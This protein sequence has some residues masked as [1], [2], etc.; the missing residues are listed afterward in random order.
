MAK[1]RKSKADE[2]SSASESDSGS[3]SNDESGSESRSESGS[4]SDSSESDNNTRTNAGTS[5]APT[6]KK[7][8]QL[9]LTVSK[10]VKNPKGKRKEIARLRKWLG[11]TQQ[12]TLLTLADLTEGE[13]V[14]P[15]CSA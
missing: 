13:F 14:A 5:A 7:V 2:E 12:K 9:A 10:D 11:F 8:S 1:G 3:E 15:P 6:K 4:G